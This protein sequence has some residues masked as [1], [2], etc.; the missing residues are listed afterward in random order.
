MAV[1]ELESNTRD[2]GGSSWTATGENYV[3]PD[4]IPR[5]EGESII[6]VECAEMQE[7]YEDGSIFLRAEGLKRLSTDSKIVEI[8]EGQADYIY[9]NGIRVY[10]PMKP[11]RFTY[12]ITQ[13]LELTEDR[14]PKYMFMV[15]YYIL[16]ALRTLK[17]EPDLDRLFSLKDN[18]F[19]ETQLDFDE[20]DGNNKPSETFASRLA[21]HVDYGGGAFSRATSYHEKTA[22]LDLDKKVPVSLPLRS[23]VDVLN[24]ENVPQWLRT[25]I[26]DSLKS[27]Y[28]LEAIGVH[29][30]ET[31]DM[32]PSTAD[33]DT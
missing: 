33:I 32:A 2:E 25:A 1:R 24:N 7:A 17:E 6:W 9:M 29:M 23:W 5:Q 15:H 21:Y 19:F 31:L 28:E 16:G 8:Y 12:N 4:E 26:A 10:K 18:Q 20:T 11:T 22:R 13:A 30:K 3:G 27:N 14:T